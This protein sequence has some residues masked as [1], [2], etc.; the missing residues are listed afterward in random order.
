MLCIP[1]G[2]PET[3]ARLL[4]SARG[5]LYTFR[6][7]WSDPPSAHWPEK[8]MRLVCEYR[9]NMCTLAGLLAPGPWQAVDP[10]TGDRWARCGGNGVLIPLNP[11][12]FA[13]LKTWTVDNP[14]GSRA[15]PG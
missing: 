8:A 12:R 5:G 4:H 15:P 1:Q 6:P 7:F 13:G 3:T 9:C 11:A 14:G 2:M 10:A